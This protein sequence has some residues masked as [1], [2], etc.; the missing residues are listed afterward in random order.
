[1]AVQSP[2]IDVDESYHLVVASCGIRD[3]RSAVGVTDEHDRPLDRLHQVGEVLGVALQPA[4][5]VG[6]TDC[7]V[8]P[9]MQAADDAIEARGISPGAVD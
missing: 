2:P 7:A 6:K 3:D 9:V 1:M 8:A 4:Q 5:R